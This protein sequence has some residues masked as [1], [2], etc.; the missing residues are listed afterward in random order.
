VEAGAEV[1]ISQPTVH[2]LQLK[3]KNKKL[4][5]EN[6]ARAPQAAEM[7]GRGLRWFQVGEAVDGDGGMAECGIDGR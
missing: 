5:T 4:K 3:T 1:S 2:S 7:R 6:F